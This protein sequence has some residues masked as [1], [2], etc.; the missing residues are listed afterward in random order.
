MASNSTAT[1]KLNQWL[2]S[3]PVLR[4]DFNSDNQKIEAAMRNMPRFVAGSYIGTGNYGPEH[5]KRLTFTFTPLIVVVVADKGGSLYPGAIFLHN[6]TQS[7]GLGH[8]DSSSETMQLH[9]TWED[10]AVSWYTDRS[11]AEPQL[12]EQGTTYYYFALGVS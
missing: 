4:S 11:F 8:H 9:I 10:K 3:D 5:P 7:S 6:Q 2:A 12:T 1:L